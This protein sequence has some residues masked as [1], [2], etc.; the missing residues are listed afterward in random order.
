MTTKWQ[1]TNC[2]KAAPT[3]VAHLCRCVT[4]QWLLH[5]LSPAHLNLPAL[6]VRYINK[7]TI[8][9]IV[10]EALISFVDKLQAIPHTLL[11]L[12]LHKVVT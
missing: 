1:N 10:Q 9:L 3:T 4:S 6:L 2:A 8:V 5:K 7:W 11:L 12:P